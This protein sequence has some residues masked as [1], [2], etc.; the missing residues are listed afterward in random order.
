MSSN[1]YRE[2]LIYEDRL[3]QLLNCEKEFDESQDKDEIINECISEIE[4]L[5]KPNCDD[6]TP[7]CG[8]CVSCGCYSNHDVLDPDDAISALEDLKE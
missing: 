5:I 1:G 4:K 6:H 2:V 7:Y 3:K 8:A